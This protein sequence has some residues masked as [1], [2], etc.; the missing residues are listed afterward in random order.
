MTSFLTSV[1]WTE[2]PVFIGDIISWMGEAFDYFG[3]AVLGAFILL[4][5]YFLFPAVMTAIMG[6]FLDDVCDAVEEKHYP[7]LAKAR[8]IP[9]LENLMNSLKFLGMVILINIAAL[10]FY[11]LTFWFGFGILLYYLINGYLLGREFYEQVAHRR[12]NGREARVLRKQ[13]RGTVMLFGFGA[14]FLMTVPILNL[15]APIVATAAMVHIFMKIWSPASGDLTLQTEE[16]DKLQCFI[17][18]RSHLGDLR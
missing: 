6:L 4:V 16:L 12:M 10:P 2:L 5:T 14:A 15:L 3:G 11:I 13:K 8:Q 9:F 7:G 17:L 1:V 18:C